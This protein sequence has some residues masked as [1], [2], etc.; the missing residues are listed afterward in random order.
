MKQFIWTYGRRNIITNPRLKHRMLK[1]QFMTIRTNVTGDT[2][3]VTNKN[4]FRNIS[5][6]KNKSS[7]RFWFLPQQITISCNM[8]NNTTKVTDR[9]K[10]KTCPQTIER[11]KSGTSQQYSP[12]RIFSHPYS[13]SFQ[14]FR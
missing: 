14:L 7:I 10:N 8:A 3:K 6:P 13:T 5:I 4:K 2:T 9:H 1:F 12:W 11:I